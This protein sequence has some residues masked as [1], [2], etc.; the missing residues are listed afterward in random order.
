MKSVSNLSILRKRTI[1][2][3]RQL[4]AAVNRDISSSTAKE[5]RNQIERVSQIWKAGKETVIRRHLGL[6]GP[7]A[8]SLVLA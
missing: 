2:V 1:K 4:W 3:R 5:K 8:A 6:T 7:R